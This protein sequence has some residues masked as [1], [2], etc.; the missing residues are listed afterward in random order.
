MVGYVAKS[1]VYVPFVTV[2]VEPIGLV[3]E[4]LATVGKVAADIMFTV[5][6]PPD[7]ALYADH[8][9]DEFKTAK[10]TR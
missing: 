7:A 2:M 8:V 5:V 3:A 10:R 6:T 9:P 1:A 4:L